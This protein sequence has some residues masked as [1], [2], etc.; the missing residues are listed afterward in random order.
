LRHHLFDL[1]L[2]QKEQGF[3][4]QSEDTVKSFL[5]LIC[6]QPVFTAD[7]GIVK[8]VVDWIL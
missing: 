8:C 3:Y 7:P 6:A 4:V 2:K 5:G 1:N